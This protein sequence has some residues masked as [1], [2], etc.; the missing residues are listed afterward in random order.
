MGSRVGMAGLALA[1]LAA[2]GWLLVVRE[3]PRATASAT[4]DEAERE[5]ATGVP[6][7]T[8]S[9]ADAARDGDGVAHEQDVATPAEPGESPIAEAPPPETWTLWGFVRDE[10]TNNPCPGYR[11]L[12]TSGITA[13]CNATGMFQ[14]ELDAARAAPGKHRTFHVYSPDGARVATVRKALEPG[15]V[16]L[17]DQVTVL[18]GRVVDPAGRPVPAEAVVI[19]APGDDHIAS[20]GVD[21][22]DG[23]FRAP[24]ASKSVEHAGL[25]VQVELDGAT[26]PLQCPTAEL[27]QPE[28]ATLV[29][30]LC[31]VRFH[32]RLS[33]GTPPT[34]TL[35][36]FLRR[37]NERRM[38]RLVL[39]RPAVDPNLT[40]FPLDEEGFV[41]VTLERGLA[42]VTVEASCTGYAPWVETLP[43]PQCGK[44]WEIP[45]LK[46]GP[47][48]LISGRVLSPEGDPLRGVQVLCRPGAADPE[49]T[50][51]LSPW[52]V[53]TG[54]DGT[55][56]VPFA[57]GRSAVLSAN[58]GRYRE[59]PAR[60]VRGGDRDIE[61]QFD[62]VQHVVLDLL[63]PF[64]GPVRVSDEASHFVLFLS[65]GDT[66]DG[67][68]SL[69]S[70]K[71]QD[72]PVGRHRACVFAGEPYLF[73]AMDVDVRAGSDV[74]L[75]VMLHP[76]FST[77]GRV[78]D[79]SGEPLAGARV[80]LVD[81]PWP[82]LGS[83]LPF[84][85]RSRS[86]GW[87]QVFLADRPRAEL[88]LSYEGR[89][90]VRVLVDADTPATWTIP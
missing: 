16:L 38:E 62:S 28:G 55:F 14:L 90:P 19:R 10:A 78:V 32:V 8:S 49:L 29:L 40:L 61:L 68:G 50:D 81:A 12:E 15:L 85:S 4:V 70:I 51:D 82:Q 26:Y 52:P 23:T 48:D 30:D 58:M 73:G 59:I 66:R 46:L 31:D 11:V 24:V 2:V 3:S 79:V 39:A 71:M 76:A 45:L 9:S 44:V 22:R 88:E 5:P 89:E 77:N 84:S 43:G 57:Q 18:Y 60:P 67:V 86:D 27:L 69:T 87:F 34:A 13:L 74:R 53:R 54:E 75:D 80:R 56:R 1:A 42:S 25:V 37:P 20:A 7:V 6:E 83:D 21:G 63:G 33:D 17:V 64:G 36:L 41:D 35:H 47:D 72:I 65:D